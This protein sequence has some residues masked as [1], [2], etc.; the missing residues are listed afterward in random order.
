MGL[1]RPFRK[2]SAYFGNKLRDRGVR[3]PRFMLIR[4]EPFLRGVADTLTK[5]DVVI[6]LGA[7]IGAASVEFAHNAAKVYAFEPHPEI[8]EQ[9]RHAVR[10]YPN[11]EPINA[12]ISTKA[13]KAK[14]FF[15]PPKDKKQFEGSTLIE[16]KSNVSYDNAFEV[17]TVSLADFVQG[18]GKRVRMIKMDIEGAEYRVISGLLETEAVH[19]IDKIWVEPHEDR[20]PEL[21]AE[22][23]AVE[24]RIAELDLTDK[25]DF[26]WP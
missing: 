23:A 1:R 12:A 3:V 22:R 11:I 2:L 24:K 9:L 7:H 15:E 19:L 14:L 21:K 13:G 26:N 16:G 6:D 4:K 20:I 10:N 25:F 18:L 17:D 5:D 8:F